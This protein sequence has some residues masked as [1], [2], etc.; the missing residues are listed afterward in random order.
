M[1]MARNADHWRSVYSRPYHTGI[2]RLTYSN[3]SGVGTGE[4]K[5]AGGVTAICGANG[6]GKTTL[7]LAIQAVL[8]PTTVN[9]RADTQ[10]RLQG[11]ELEA[12][13]IHNESP[14]HRS[15]SV[16]GPS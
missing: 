8:N 12:D 4:F 15:I 16:P 7:L 9:S 11:A 10:F 1:R 5:V 6:A 14:I 3:L 2:G 13:L